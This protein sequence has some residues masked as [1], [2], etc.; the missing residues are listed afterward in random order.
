MND[1]DLP[2]SLI[3]FTEEYIKGKIPEDTSKFG[4]LFDEYVKKFNTSP[5]TEP[6]GFT[7]EKWCT[8]LE[9]CI[10]N[11]ITVENLLHIEHNEDWDD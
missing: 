10:K 8:I 11:N 7:E 3:R 1:I 4:Q 5:P 9:T 6:G 2:E